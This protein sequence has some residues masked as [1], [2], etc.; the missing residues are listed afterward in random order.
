MSED[1]S[2]DDPAIPDSDVLL[3]RLPDRPNFLV[4][5]LVTGSVTFQRAAF[6][7][8][9]NDGMSVS[10]ESL[11]SEHGLDPKQ[12]VQNALTHRAAAFKVG[13]VRRAGAGVVDTPCQHVEW[14]PEDLPKCHACVRTEE[15]TPPKPKWDA[16]RQAII[17][18]AWL[19]W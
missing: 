10:R 6:K 14:M 17:E 11:L 13:V 4:R 7:Y 8:N 15:P 12:A 18:H 1:W 19:R 3:R 9:A 5:D 16:I 2:H